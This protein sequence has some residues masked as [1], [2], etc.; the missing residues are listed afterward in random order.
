MP[1]T[2]GA[3]HVDTVFV[4]RLYGTSSDIVLGAKGAGSSEHV[5]FQVDDLTADLVGLNKTDTIM[6]HAGATPTEAE[7]R[8][9]LLGLLPAGGSW[10]LATKTDIDEIHY[11]RPTGWVTGQG[12]SYGF[13]LTKSG[14]TFKRSLLV[15]GQAVTV[16]Y[17]AVVQPHVQSHLHPGRRPAAARG[18]AAHPPG[19]PSVSRAHRALAALAGAARTALVPEREGASRQRVDAR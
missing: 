16:D 5:A 8:S 12:F 7:C 19:L 11:Y 3:T 10:S 1:V 6:T 9:F 18:C 15:D 13:Q 4:A 17:I 2:Q 14:S